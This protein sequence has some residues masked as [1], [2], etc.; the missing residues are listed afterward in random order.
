[1]QATIREPPSIFTGVSQLWKRG[2]WAERKRRPLAGRSKRGTRRRVSIA[3]THCGGIRD[4]VQSRDRL[5]R[6]PTRRAVIATPACNDGGP[7][8]EC[9]RRA[10]NAD[11]RLLGINF[12]FVI[13]SHSC[14]CLCTAWA[15]S[16][17]AIFYRGRHG[18]E[19]EEGKEDREGS[20]QEGGKED[21]K[22]KE[23][24]VS[25]TDL[26]PP[27]GRN[28]HEKRDLPKDMKR[29]LQPFGIAAR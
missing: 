26:L 20:H 16:L 4:R 14:A 7:E 25:A 11:S 3:P 2:L 17:R 23:V 5:K 10:T 22:E 1:M 9:L 29:P 13:A 27:S 6:H 21:F 18:Q 19:S 15:C 28:P 12:A 24:V 8:G